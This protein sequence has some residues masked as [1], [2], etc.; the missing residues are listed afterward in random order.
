MTVTHPSNHRQ[1]L[2]LAIPMIIANISTPLLG[3]VDTAVMGH[4]DTPDYLAGV[5][6][7]GLIFSFI[8]WGFSFLRMGTT[9][10]T[11]Q[12]Y[13]NS[14]DSEIKLI[15]AR[16][17]L[18]AV[19]IAVGLLLLQYPIRLFSFWL[20]NSSAA[21]E[22]L[23]IRYFNIRIWSAPASLGHYVLLGWFIGIQDVKS[24]LYIVLITNLCNIGLDI[25]FVVYL[26]MD[27]S[28][29]AL[30]SVLA[31]YFGLLLGLLLLAWRLKSYRTKL[32]WRQLFD[33]KKL[34]VLLTINNDIF[35]RTLCLIFTF[36]FFT[37]QG[38]RYGEV[39]L[40]ANA[41]LLNFQMFMAFALDGFAHAAE[42]L[43]G[44]AIGAANKVLFSRSVRTT[45]LWSY[46]VTIGFTI[47][48]LYFGTDIVRLLT[49]LETVR[50]TAFKYLPWV[51]IT[52]LL[53]FGSF[54]L[55][56]IFIGATLSR[57]MRNT[58]LLSVLFC[59]LPAWYFSQ[60]LQN[61][62]LWLSFCIFML[63]RSILM[64]YVFK[65]KQSQII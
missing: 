13:G 44:K 57:E 7:G 34:K 24:P 18:I 65:R 45:A 38:A 17:F 50:N 8:Y 12:A 21:V 3:L 4:L 46:A 31:E 60:P 10:I 43:V 29:V 19:I 32:D 30:A 39:I 63:A 36:A 52:P 48:Y 35:I 20:I 33:R 61:H 6:L 14:D 58:M 1:I 5:A 64:V 51:V 37:A 40:A 59:F 56:G 42:A 15:L 54:L 16:T 26:G 2:R 47:L 11:A 27:I 62:G 41:V 49:N 28:G 23:S 53:S 25:L 55:D 9:G 22:Q